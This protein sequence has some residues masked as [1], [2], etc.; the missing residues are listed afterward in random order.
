MAAVA[1]SATSHGAS[2]LAIR[3]NEIDFIGDP[4]CFSSVD[5]RRFCGRLQLL[6]GNGGDFG[7]RKKKKVNR[8]GAEDA[9]TS[10][11]V[12]IEE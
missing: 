5:E 7:N 12:V 4:L 8:K 2:P 1:P 10:G 9:V 11:R 3:R 6:N